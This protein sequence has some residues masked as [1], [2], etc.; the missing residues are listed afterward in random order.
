MRSASYRASSEAAERIAWLLPF[1]SMRVP[2]PD[3][4]LLEPGKHRRGIDAHPLTDL[5]QRQALLVEVDSLV[6]LV[7][8]E[9]ASPHRHVVPMQDLAHRPPVDAKLFAE[10]VDSCAGRVPR[11]EVLDLLTVELPGRARYPASSSRTARI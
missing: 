5:R 9:A 11:D 8:G 6:G 1:A 3:P 7:G 4:P 10:L 2:H